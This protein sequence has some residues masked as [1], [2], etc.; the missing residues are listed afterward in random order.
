MQNRYFLNHNVEGVIEVFD[1]KILDI[2]KRLLTYKQFVDGEE[3]NLIG[4]IPLGDIRCYISKTMKFKDKNVEKVISPITFDESV[5]TIYWDDKRDTKYFVA[6]VTGDY[7]SS[8]SK[9]KHFKIVFDKV[10]IHVDYH[11]QAWSYKSKQLEYYIGYDSFKRS[12]YKSLL[13]FKSKHIFEMYSDAKSMVDHYYKLGKNVR[14]KK[15][16]ELNLELHAQKKMRLYHSIEEPRLWDNIG[17][18][19]R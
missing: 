17:Y 1:V 18:N 16:C 5:K 12:D 3:W 6:D 14:A 7:K 4:T 10:K 9:I 15:T 11:Y 8:I 13:D 19:M 2:N